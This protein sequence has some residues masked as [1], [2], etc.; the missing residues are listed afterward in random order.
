MR[1]RAESDKYF[2]SR[3]VKF[4]W[5]GWQANELPARHEHGSYPAFQHRVS[6]TPE[7]RRTV[8]A[9][10]AGASSEGDRVTRLSDRA[11]VLLTVGAFLAIV[12][13]IAVIGTILA[14]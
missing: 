14:G 7:V 5:S 10:A 11:V 6:G 3:Y 12:V 2:L 9:S 13:G 4:A 1:E 8:N